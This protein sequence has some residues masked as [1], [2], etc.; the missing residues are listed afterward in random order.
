MLEG[1]MLNFVA[2]FEF[3]L[4]CLMT[5]LAFHGHLKRANNSCSENPG[6]GAIP[7]C[8]SPQDSQK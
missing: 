3:V 6:D 7:V 8:L 2:L 1:H 4:V 5:A